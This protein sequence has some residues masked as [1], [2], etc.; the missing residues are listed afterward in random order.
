M[1]ARNA[2]EARAT[3]RE[4]EEREAEKA[5][6]LEA[7]RRSE[8]AV[9]DVPSEETETDASDEALVRSIVADAVASVADAAAAEASAEANAAAMDFFGLADAP[10]PAPSPAHDPFAALA[11]L[12]P[13]SATTAALDTGS[14]DANAQALA[15]GSLM[16]F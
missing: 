2:D 11:S 1:E 5:T 12:E 8:A 9:E 14:G 13:A 7:A 3:A 4:A 16:D 10:A 6:A 15:S